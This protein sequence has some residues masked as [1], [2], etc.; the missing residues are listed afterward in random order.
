MTMSV[1]D[2]QQWIDSEEYKEKNLA[3]RHV[4][5]NPARTCQPLGAF[6]AARGFKGALPFVHGS[7]GCNAY[8]RSILAR[9]YREPAP[10]VST[11][12]T[13]DA[14]VF[15]GQ[16]NLTDGLQNAYALYKPEL[17][18]V[19]TTCMA[20]VIGDDVSAYIANARIKEA[21][22][23]GFPLPYANT[24]SFI[25]SHIDGYDN[26]IKSILEYF[27]PDA[28]DP[29]NAAGNKIN[30]IPGFDN[31]TGNL[32]E[33]KRILRLFGA[34][35]TILGDY[36]ETFDA[37]LTGE[38]NMYPGG[39]TMAEIRQ[40][41]N[42]AATFSMQT[43]AARKT[44]KFVKEHFRGEAVSLNMPVGIGGTDK[45]L[46]ELSR[47][48]NRPVPE[49]LS[50][51][52]GIAV[53]A[54]TD[55]H[56]YIH[57]RKFSLFGDPDYLLALVSWLLEMGGEPRHIL[58]SNGTKAFDQ[59]MQ[60]LIDSS[61]F[62]ANARVFINKDLWHLRSLLVTEP[63]DMVIGSSHGKFAARDAGIPLMRIGFPIYDRVNLHRYP[64]VGYQGAIN[65]TT[66]I[67]NCFLDKLD[68][69]CDSDHFELMR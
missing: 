23:E 9:H 48:L 5:I 16:A 2:I 3:R 68:R 61:P 28:A 17:M 66:R 27:L 53:D 1:Q 29:Q 62:G 69:E 46:M 45:F 51:E 14:A 10:G 54:M 65:L 19:F 6:L 18:P 11:S 26:M 33:Y 31:I 64:I 30:I 38:Y 55:A 56:Q 13:E 47:V 7:Q 36:S 49:E 58:C 57:G 44:M 24:P 39:T 40:A 67:A 25:G 12:M 52:R 63:V 42:A 4:I 22:P 34:G 37:P 15:G 43:F 41:S 50:A 59:Q 8:F 35:H 20:E 60:A 21:V 32:K